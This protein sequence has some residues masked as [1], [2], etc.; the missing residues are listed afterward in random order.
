MKKRI[1]KRV[2]VWSIMFLSVAVLM[3]ADALAGHC[4]GPPCV[5]SNDIIDGQVTKSDIKR[6]AV[7]RKHIRKN[8]VT[9]V[10]VMDGSLKGADIDPSTTL[11]VGS[12]T[13]TGDVGVG[14]GGPNAALDVKGSIG[15]ALTGLVTVSNGGTTVIGIGTLFTQELNVGDAIKIENESFTVSA[16]TDDTT[17][18]IDSPH[19][20]GALDVTAFANSDLLLLETGD[21]V[22]KVVVDKS[23]NVGIGT[24][25]PGES[26]DVSGLMI[27]KIARATGNGP[28][29]GTDNGQIASRVLNIT[30]AKAD[31]AI[32]IGYTDNL[33][34]IGNA[35]ACRWEIRADGASSQVQPLVYDYYSRDTDNTHRSRAVVGYY[36]GLSAGSHQIQIW[37]GP[38][39]GFPLTDCYTGWNNSTWVLEAEEVY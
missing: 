29:D 13:T 12:L 27:R 10:K 32:R 20:A 8:S 37:V 9:G 24:M 35:R 15:K 22:G 36:Q 3:P 17:L 28:N 26:L 21:A 23:G 16:I 4:A 25:S 38:A 5:D 34:V 7:R 30:K 11:N 39:P 6:N 19:S 1:F 2:I 14:T 31:T 33:R 18:E